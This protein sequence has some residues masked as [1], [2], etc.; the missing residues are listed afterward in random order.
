MLLFGFLGS[1]CVTVKAKTS[2]LFPGVSQ[3]P[4]GYDFNIL[5][6]Y[7]LYIVWDQRVTSRRGSES[8]PRFVLGLASITKAFYYRTLI[9]LN[10]VP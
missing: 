5:G 6:F 7:S 1:D 8:Q 3:R 10:R 9:L 4:S 2:I